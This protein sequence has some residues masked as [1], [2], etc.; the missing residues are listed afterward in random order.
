MI[1]EIVES[2]IFDREF[3]QRSVEG[4]TCTIHHRR[5]A[6]KRANIHQLDRRYE[7]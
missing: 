7:S 1:S 2:D 6:W 5:S 4:F 3:H